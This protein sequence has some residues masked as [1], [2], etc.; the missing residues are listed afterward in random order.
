MYLCKY[1]YYNNKYYNENIIIKSTIIWPRVGV[2]CICE[3]KKDYTALIIIKPTINRP[4]VDVLCIC[5]GGNEHH[6]NRASETPFNCVSLVCWW[7]PNIECRLRSFVIFQGIWIR[8]AKKP[9]FYNF[10]R[11]SGPPPP[12]P[13][14]LHMTV[15]CMN[16]PRHI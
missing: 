4:R 10:S 6:Y 15:T 13:L 9:Y 14:D 2:L 16:A 3:N 7:W 12:P 8:I 5:V 11:E 1:K